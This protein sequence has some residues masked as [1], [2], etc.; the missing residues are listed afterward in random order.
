MVV[1]LVMV[2]SSNAGQPQPALFAVPDLPRP[3]LATVNNGPDLSHVHP[4]ARNSAMAS[5]RIARMSSMRSN[6]ARARLGAPPGFVVPQPPP[7]LLVP[8]PP[9]AAPGW[10]PDDDSGAENAEKHVSYQW[11]GDLHPYVEATDA[12]PK[13]GRSSTNIKHPGH[14][15]ICALNP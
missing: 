7:T 11:N 4:A 6:T 12:F 2:Y 1:F 9:L 13:T 10:H 5:R 14:S 3:V 15:D 8:R